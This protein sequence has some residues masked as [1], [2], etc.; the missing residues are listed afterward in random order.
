M[1]SLVN[2]DITEIRQA[3]AG[4]AGAGF[5]PGALGAALLGGAAAIGFAMGSWEQ[6][7]HAYLLAVMYVTSLGV[8]GLFF[9]LAHH[10]TGGRWGTTV[11]RLAEITAGTLAVSFAMYLLILV[12]G[13]LA[14]SDALYP[15][16]NPDMFVGDQIMESKRPYLD[17]TWFTIR[18]CVYYVIWIAMA[19]TMLGLSTRQDSSEPT[20]RARAMQWYAGP[21]M[22]IFAL[23]LNFASFDWMMTLEPHWFSTMFGVYFFAGS[24]EG[25][26]AWLILLCVVLQ[27]RGVLTQSV[28][29]E[30]YHDLAKLMFAFVVFW[31]YIAFSQYMLIWYAAIPEET[32]WYDIRQHGVWPFWGL[33]LA[34]GHLLV[35]FLGFMSKAVR[36]NKQLM[37]FWACWMLAMHWIDLAYVILPQVRAEGSVAVTIVLGLIA[38]AGALGVFLWAW[39]SGAAGKW[40]LPVQDPRLPIALS[41]HNH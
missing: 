17:P 2:A 19:W 13:V 5:L 14:G 9:V 10:L 27:G 1:A 38:T 11:R 29:T 8:G 39:M 15:W 40:L 37:L 33:A 7:V 3:S 20:K 34:A 6:F 24:F 25:F 32:L 31:G 4:L 22:P 18:S 12:L 23:S 16:V 26:L 35:P 21:M 30:H 28:T 36:R 41:Y